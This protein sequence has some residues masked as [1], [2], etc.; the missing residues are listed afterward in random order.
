MQAETHDMG[1]GG[2]KAPLEPISYRE[3]FDP[4]AVTIAASNMRHSATLG[5]PELMPQNMR[6]KCLIVGSS[7]SLKNQLPVIK[8]LAKDETTKIFAINDALP[9]LLDNGVIPYATVVFEIYGDPGVVVKRLHPEINYYVCSMCDP[10]TFEMLKDN[11]VIIWHLD[12][13]QQEHLDLIG[14]FKTNFIIGGGAYTFTRTLPIA[15]ALGFRDFEVFGVDC[16]YEEGGESHFFGTPEE[17]SMEI[18]AEATDGTQRLFVTKPYLARQADEFRRICKL[19]H[20]LFKMK[21]HGDGLLG[22]I[23]RSMYPQFYP[24]ESEQ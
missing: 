7:P 14:L 1:T 19:N 20:W 3:S 22:W 6:G 15:V 5:L 10:S 8:E 11:K 17:G 4:K 23:H 21:V 18:R 12:S 9:Y 13:D 2:V 16:S 24:Q